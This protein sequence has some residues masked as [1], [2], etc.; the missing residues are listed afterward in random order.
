[1]WCLSGDSYKASQQDISSFGS[2][3]QFYLA[4]GAGHIILFCTDRVTICDIGYTVWDIGYTVRYE[5][6]VN[7]DS[8]VKW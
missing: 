6:S 2:A 1:M 8:K 3:S 5:N 7:S 4:A